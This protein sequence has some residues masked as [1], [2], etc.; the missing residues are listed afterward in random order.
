M[1]A[2]IVLRNIAGLAQ[3][4][5]HLLPSAGLHRHNRANRASIRLRPFEPDPDPMVLRLQIVAQQRWGL[6]HIHNQHVDVAIVVEVSEG[7]A[8][9]RFAFQYPTPAE[10][11]DIFEPLS[12][13][14]T[15]YQARIAIL[16]GPWLGIEL[17]I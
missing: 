14:V 7:C 8:P 1:E 15:I 10:V 16:L 6:V 5:L 4:G 17:G 13:E 12:R 2:Q 9:A 11:A 3:D